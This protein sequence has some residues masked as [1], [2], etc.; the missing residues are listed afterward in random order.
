MTQIALRLRRRCSPSNNEKLR[1]FPK[2][3]VEIRIVEHLS[4]SITDS[5]SGILRRLDLNQRPSIGCCQYQVSEIPL[6]FYRLLAVLLLKRPLDLL[7]HLR[8]RAFY[9]HE[10]S[11]AFVKDGVC[12]WWLLPWRSVRALSRMQL[13]RLAALQDS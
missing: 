7:F 9:F 6:G 12:R 3:R 4:E 2:P 13:C 1:I 5:L 11:S 10:T 8:F